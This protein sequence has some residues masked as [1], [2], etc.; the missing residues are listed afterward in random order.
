LFQH[1]NGEITLPSDHPGVSKRP[2][3]TLGSVG[4]LF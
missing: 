4:P 3:A 1:Q 2:H